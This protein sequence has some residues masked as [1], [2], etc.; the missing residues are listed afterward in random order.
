MPRM[1]ESVRKSQRQ[2]QPYSLPRNGKLSTHPRKGSPLRKRMRGME[3]RRLDVWTWVG[4]PDGQRQAAAGGPGWGPV[5]RSGGFL[6]PLAAAA[7]ADP[8]APSPALL[9]VLA[10]PVITRSVPH[11]LDGSAALPPIPITSSRLPQNHALLFR[12][13]SGDRN[14]SRT[15]K[16]TRKLQGK[17]AR[18]DGQNGGKL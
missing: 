18:I 15:L 3:T 14:P 2:L 13:T 16:K 1:N 8:S 11:D 4:H 6:G 10:N 12:V 5:G 9:L 17:G 7:P